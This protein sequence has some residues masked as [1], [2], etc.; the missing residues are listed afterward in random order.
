[1]KT[2]VIKKPYQVVDYTPKM[3]AEV[4][5]CVN[6]PLYFMENFMR[7]QHPM[8]GT[9]P[10]KAFGYQTGMIEAFH[11]NRNCIALTAR[12]MGK[13]IDQ[14]SMITVDGEQVPVKSLFK[15]SRR[16]RLV[17]WLEGKLVEMA[18]D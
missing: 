14:N 7:I 13:C 1:M 8:K 18:R 5:R 2:E 9:L 15:L 3:A 10:F 6:D 16:E 17:G 12:Q 4:V 11:K